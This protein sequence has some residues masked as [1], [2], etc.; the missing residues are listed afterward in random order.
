[1]SEMEGDRP[2]FVTKVKTNYFQDETN[3]RKT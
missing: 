1:M 2:I 3:R